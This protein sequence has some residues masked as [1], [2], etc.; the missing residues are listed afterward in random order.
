[1]RRNSQPIPP[2]PEVRLLRANASKINVNMPSPK[3][4]SKSPTRIK[5]E[6]FK[7]RQGS[8]YS[9]SPSRFKRSPKVPDEKEEHEIERKNSLVRLKRRIEKSQSRMLLRNESNMT[10]NS[11]SKSNIKK[12]EESFSQSDLSPVKKKWNFEC[13]DYEIESALLSPALTAKTLKAT[14]TFLREVEDQSYID[15]YYIHTN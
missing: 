1:M 5:Y 4:I 13:N 14:D 12:Q 11:K 7:K 10:I 2:T 6:S 8:E 15:N 9:N 3:N